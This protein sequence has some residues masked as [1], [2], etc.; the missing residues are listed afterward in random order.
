[1]IDKDKFY[2]K[3]AIA[4]KYYSIFIEHMKK[5][6]IY[7]D[8][9][10][11]P[12]AGNGSFF[13]LLPIDKRLGIDILPEFDGIIKGDFLNFVPSS[14]KKY[15]VIG[16]PPFG[17]VSSLAVK[18]FNKSALFSQAIGFIVPRTFKRNSIKN[19][20]N[21]YFHLIYEENIPNNSFYPSMQAKCVFQ[22]WIK[23]DYV[24][25]KIELN[26]STTDF[27]FCSNSIEADF[28]L[29]AYGSN[30]GQIV[31]DNLSELAIRS[32]HFIKCN[33]NSTIVIEK[34][35]KLDY[36]ISKDTVRQDSIGR[37]ELVDLYNKYN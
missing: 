24:R 17:R 37:K 27:S 5:E 25:N 4:E 34:L 8:I 26:D 6:N 23:K 11:E 32:W 19:R 7:F 30:C 21:N 9:I 10:L 13:K 20:L 3:D 28:A 12:S 16:N 31:K 35:K 1:L 18:F 15:I 14:N 36:S 33:I 22:I 29:R 2:T